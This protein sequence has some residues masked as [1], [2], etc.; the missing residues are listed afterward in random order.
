M[1]DGIGRSF[2]GW[3]LTLE[4]SWGHV[5][6][7]IS[8]T[9]LSSRK[10]IPDTSWWQYTF[11][12]DYPL[13]GEDAKTE[14]PPY[15]YPVLMRESEHI[16]NVLLACP[17]VAVFNYFF[18][19]ILKPIVKP[20]YRKVRL[21][22]DK[23]VKDMSDQSLEYSLTYAHARPASFGKSLTAVSFYGNDLNEVLWFRQSIPEMP[24]FSCGLR[25]A[26]S[27]EQEV[28]RI[29]SNGKISFQFLGKG[30]LM[31]INKALNFLNTHKYMKV[32]SWSGGMPN[33]GSLEY[34]FRDG[35][36]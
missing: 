15:Y 14:F 23:L 22:V 16:G 5:L 1:A 17:K 3:I 13:M 10:S 27:T 29:W 8:S 9:V 28:I 6:S 36:V 18:E 31:D 4:E 20:P 7:Q 30:S 34:S 19:T 12:S 21:S 26:T 25:E 32:V 33:Y 11:L 2:S 35:S 24:F